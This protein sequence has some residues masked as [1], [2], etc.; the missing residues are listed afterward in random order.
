MRLTQLVQCIQ[1]GGDRAFPSKFPTLSPSILVVVA[2]L[3][4]CFQAKGGAPLIHLETVMSK[5]RQFLESLKALV[6]TPL[7]S[8]TKF[9]SLG[10]A[11]QAH[12]LLKHG[13]TEVLSSDP[14][15]ILKKIYLFKKYNDTL[16]RRWRSQVQILQQ[17]TLGNKTP[18]S[19]L[20]HTRVLNGARCIVMVHSDPLFPQTRVQ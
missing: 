12:T 1:C 19:Q 3:G 17:E 10:L 11:C 15:Q 13:P 6:Q 16:I 7:S 8:Y 4:S 18:Y 14:L 9:P 5:L 2:S 20:M